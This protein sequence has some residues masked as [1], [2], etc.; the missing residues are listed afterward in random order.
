M[1]SHEVYES[2]PTIPKNI[3]EVTPGQQA[4][5]SA[6]WFLCYLKLLG[7][8]RLSIALVGG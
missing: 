1:V 6:N 2:M 7:W 8:C 3:T 5:D 4:L